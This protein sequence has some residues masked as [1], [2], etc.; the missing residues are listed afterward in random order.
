MVPLLMEV[1]VIIIIIIIIIITTTIFVVVVIIF[2]Q[3]P[4][5]SSFSFSFLYIERPLQLR[6]VSWCMLT[7]CYDI[8]VAFL[9][10]LII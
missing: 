6:S 1:F 5:K 4:R 3:L 2:C 7:T 8:K 9:K 10:L